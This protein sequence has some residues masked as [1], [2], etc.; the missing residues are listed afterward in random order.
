MDSFNLLL[1]EMMEK[2]NPDGLKMICSNLEAWEIYMPSKVKEKAHS[3][4]TSLHKEGSL[5]G[6]EDMLRLYR[7]LAK[8]SKNMGAAKVFEK[9]EEQGRFRH[10]LKFHLMWAESYAQ[11]GDLN[12]FVN[13]LSLARRRLHDFP[14][15]EVEAGF[16]DLL[17]QYFPDSKIFNDDEETMA[18]LNTNRAADSKLKRNRRRSSLANFEYKAM[19]TP[20]PTVETASSYFGPNKRSI[21]RHVLVDRPND[22]YIAPS[23][24]ELRE[25]MIADQQTLDDFFHAP[26]DI[27]AVQSE[28]TVNVQPSSQLS[29]EVQFPVSSDKNLVLFPKRNRVLETVEEC[30]L[31]FSNDEKRR[32]VPSPAQPTRSSVSTALLQKSQPEVLTSSSNATFI[33]GSSFTEKAYNDMKAMFSDTV[34]INQGS[35]RGIT[36]ETTLPVSTP[37]VEAFEVFVDEELRQPDSEAKGAENIPS[38]H[39]VKSHEERIPFQT[40]WLSNMEGDS[41][42]RLDPNVQENCQKSGLGDVL[43]RRS[44]LFIDDEETVAGAKFSALG[45]DKK[46]DRGIVTSTPAH[47]TLKPPSHE[48]FFAPL[49]KE[50]EEQMRK[51]KDEELLYAQSA[52]MRRRSLAL[53]KS[54]TV[55]KSS[56]PKV[57][58]AQDAQRCMEIA[59]NRMNLGESKDAIEMNRADS[60][61]HTKTGVVTCPYVSV[62]E[63]A[64]FGGEAFNI[65][66]FI[67]QGGYAKVY[68]TYETPSC[69]WEVYICSELRTRLNKGRKFA[70]DSVMQVTEAYVFINA[71]VIFSEY[72][73]YGTLL[74]ISNKMK[75]PSWYIVLLIAIHMAKI[76]RDV[77]N[78]KVIHGDVKPDNFM[79]LNKLNDG[80]DVRMILSTPFL[81]LIDWGRAIDM[82]FLSGIT[83][84]GKSGTEKFNCSE[85]L[86]GRPWTFQTDYFGFVGTLHVI[87]FNKRLII[88]PLLEKIFHDFL[89]IPD[90]D[91]FPDWD[92]VIQFLRKTIAAEE[93]VHVMNSL[94]ATTGE[95]EATEEFLRRATALREAIA[96]MNDVVELIRQLH[97]LLKVSNDTRDVD[98]A[99]LQTLFEKLSQMF[100]GFAKEL[101]KV[102][103]AVNDWW[104]TGGSS[105]NWISVLLTITQSFTQMSYQGREMTE[106]VM[107]ALHSVILRFREQEVPFEELTRPVTEKH[108]REFQMAPGVEITGVNLSVA[109]SDGDASERSLN[110]GTEVGDVEKA[111]QAGSITEDVLEPLSLKTT[112]INEENDECGEKD[113]LLEVKQ[114]TDELLLLEEAVSSLNSLHEH[115]NFLVH[116]QDLKVDRIDTNISQAVE[117][118][119]KVKKETDEAVQLYQQVNQVVMVSIH[120]PAEQSD[121]HVV[122]HPVAAFGVLRNAVLLLFFDASDS[123]VTYSAICLSRINGNPGLICSL[124]HYTKGAEVKALALF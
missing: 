44:S 118:T 71:S 102:V 119:E 89:N 2:P 117:Y 61:D 11:S 106:S 63:M 4:V 100:K 31:E 84:T 77:H 9:V 96:K 49:N 107:Q 17:D 81:R 51:E 101:D 121:H 27:T 45:I 35:L 1:K 65:V 82:H 26:M 114:R 16:R 110:R 103:A 37:V 41:K 95:G 109:R 80:D 25:A 70:L 94:T 123:R 62:G 34:D 7:I 13:V 33:I 59:L 54:I 48:D 122:E 30:D 93:D 64:N 5:V 72:H 43:K 99:R 85:M 24:E 46:P 105:T 21:L 88:R 67:G 60:G 76:L 113:V 69:P 87:I 18:V 124:N 58:P 15:V 90:C 108:L 92:R 116:T 6:Q 42:G 55:T 83:F 12:E 78:V 39:A 14:S 86:D 68:K 10:S 40:V 28:P 36:D 22:S 23:I 47:H 32:H 29:N 98:R 79:I 57:R 56:L 66:A 111:L 120:C 19:E 20:N 8:Y 3:A 38:Q 112:E 115:L 74:D 91:H 73:P 53:S 52:F 97:N 75:D 104:A 50:L